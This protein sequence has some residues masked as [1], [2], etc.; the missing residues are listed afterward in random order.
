MPS[1]S[2]SSTVTVVAIAGGTVSTHWVELDAAI[3][4][5]IIVIVVGP[6]TVRTS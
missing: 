1:L 2:H 3:V 4:A 6:G 5:I